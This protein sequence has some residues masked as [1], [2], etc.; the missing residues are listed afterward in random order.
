MTVDSG[1][2]S[3]NG[4]N[5]LD[6]DPYFGSYSTSTK[7]VAKAGAI[8]DSQD[9]VTVP[10]L[11]TG[12][13]NL[14][15]KKSDSIL[16]SNYL[17][18]EKFNKRVNSFFISG[19]EPLT[20]NTGQYVTIYGQGF[21]RIRGTSGVYF[22]S[23]TGTSTVANYEFPKVCA[24]SI[25]SNEQIIVKVPAGLKNGDY[26]LKIKFA[27]GK[28]L[29]SKDLSP[30]NN[31]FVFDELAVL[32]PGLCKMLPIR[33]QVNTPV[34]LWGEYFGV[35][36]SNGKTL[37]YS[38][39]ATTSEIKT[40]VADT[41]AQQIDTGVPASTASG[42]VVVQKN[43]TNSNPLN[44]AVGE[45]K[46]DTECGSQICCPNG[47]YKKGRC[48]DKISECS[49]SSKNSVFEWNFNTNYSPL[50]YSCNGWAQATG[51]CQTG[52]T[53][54]NVP[55]QCS[56][57]NL[58]PVS[59]GS[60]CSTGFTYN[61]TAGKCSKDS[62]GC[63]LS[64]K[65]TKDSLVSCQK[66]PSGFLHWSVTSANAPIL[67]ADIKPGSLKTIVWINSGN[68][69]YTDSQESH[70]TCSV[71]GD[72]ESCF[73][74]LAPNNLSGKG[75]CTKASDCP[76]GSSC[77]SDGSNSFQCY[78]QATCQCCCEKGKDKRDCCAGL[79][80]AGACGSNTEPDGG[81]LGRCSGCANAGTSPA[82][83]D[84]ACNCSG[85][86]GQ[87][88]ETGDRNFPTGYCADCTSLASDTCDTHSSVCCTDSQKANT[89]RGGDTIGSII[90]ATPANTFCA[91]YDCQA[92]PNQDTCDGANPLANGV[93]S[94]QEICGQA[95]KDN[96]GSNHCSK[97]FDETTC[98]DPDDNCCWDKKNNKC[99][100]G[101]ETIRDD[102]T[103]DGYCAYYNCPTC[104]AASASGSYL[105]QASCEKNC[106]NGSGLGSTCAGAQTSSC[107]SFACASPFSCL[108]DNGQPGSSGDCGACCC[109]VGATTDSCASLNTSHP[110]LKL[111]CEPDQAPCS[112]AD[113]GL[114]CGCLGDDYC[115]NSNSDGCDLNSCCRARPEIR[116]ASTTPAERAD[117]VCR[118]ALIKVTFNQAMN[119]GSLTGNVLLL[120]R[121]APLSSCPAGTFLA[122]KSLLENNNN[123]NYLVRS[124]KKIAY[125]AQ[126]ILQIFSKQNSALA[127][128]TPVDDDVY[129]SIPG[130]VSN[131]KNNADSLVFSPSK[132][133]AANTTYY[134]IVKG[135]EALQSNSGV[136]SYWNV[137]L[138]G[139]GLKYSLD[140]PSLE[141]E[142]IKFNNLNYKN[143]YISVFK[144]LP[145]NSTNAGVCLVDHVQISPASYLFQTTDSDLSEFDSDANSPSFDSKKDNDKVF[146][147]YA[148]SSDNQY[149]APIPTVYDWD[150]NWRTD[151]HN[152]AATSTPPNLVY[153]KTL[154]T[155]GAGVKD[156][157]TKVWA[158]LA[159]KSGSITIGNGTEGSAPVYVFVCANPWPK[160]NS[161]NTWNPWADNNCQPPNCLNYNYKFYYCRDAGGPGTADDLPAINNN[162]VTVGKSPSLIC[163]DGAA[164][165]QPPLTD[166]SRCGQD[167]NGDGTPDGFC[168]YSILKESYFFRSA[169]PDIVTITSLTDEQVSG[170]VKLQWRSKSTLIYNN[171]PEQLGAYKIYYG[172][173]GG[174]Q[175]SKKIKP[176]DLNLIDNSP[177][178][179]EATGTDDY[180][181][182]LIISGLTDNQPYSFRMTALTVDNA[183][184]EL[185]DE[186]QVT[187]TDK[188]QPPVPGGFGAG[189]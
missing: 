56:P 32:S 4:I 181:C 81:T 95:C 167:K 48:V 182:S 174:A 162:P 139:Q 12:K 42:P 21:G 41:K 26:T 114:C 137:G 55:G 23:S 98:K 141:G 63:D 1:D 108:A 86:S 24:D 140:D 29:S 82:E 90:Q 147:A 87:Y 58:A 40:A 46:D 150:W 60:C 163:S 113:R 57:F 177:I 75:I 10:D 25:W 104:D 134:I 105:G 71:C 43:G 127:F 18:F 185:S 179:T 37:F 35:T 49:S 121:H 102:S 131:E 77:K 76:G 65:T 73:D 94:S 152:I 128:G 189:G 118:N 89:C 133:L 51:A 178:C 144:T 93:Y 36:G 30:P 39:I 143:S 120:E 124:F 72:D 64:F 156:A 135:D 119:V 125:W 111:K 38:E 157:S 70:D 5:L 160:V 14:F 149:L 8:P 130:V 171:N 16:K 148:Q 175:T 3:Y 59:N 17:K 188:R 159:T 158:Q 155:A 66:F 123:Q 138:N 11:K 161:D 186:M 47:T 53:C 27:D 112:G 84:A 126:N 145:D 151:D 172:V 52:A 132:L 2:L 142:S 79:T 15:V 19:F 115:G 13:T 116:T 78:E 103:N 85:H 28:E 96:P 106:S 62:S 7:G 117:D 88:C 129:C 180:I 122:D 184:S 45:C 83:H 168:I 44:F 91:Y 97:I 54:P 74:N 107:N 110:E 61:E 136:L 22:E 164:A 169:T 173:S 176:N 68:G 166:Q 109:Q 34:T 146:S 165:C 187:P 154:L 9:S 69:K 50:N 33:G 92:A 153:N 101:E 99:L 183:E 100:G 6:T 67:P 31:V 80:C 170:T 20:G